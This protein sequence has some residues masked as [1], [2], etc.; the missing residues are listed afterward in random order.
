MESPKI[1]KDLQ[2]HPVQLSTYHQYFPTKPWSSAQHLNVSWTPPGTVTPPPPWA[3]HSSAWLCYQM[4]YCVIKGCFFRVGKFIW[5]NSW[6][7]N[8][9]FFKIYFSLHQNDSKLGHKVKI[10]FLH[11]LFV[12]QGFWYERNQ[13]WG[14][15]HQKSWSSESCESTSCLPQLSWTCSA[16]S[17]S[18]P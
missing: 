6:C 18:I 11:L 9:P 12:L 3:A 16:C 4:F 8:I 7:G 5:S 13:S 17:H 2:D 14:T 15:V 1:G 10:A